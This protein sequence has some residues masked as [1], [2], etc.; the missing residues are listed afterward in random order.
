MKILSIVAL[1]FVAACAERDA[2]YQFVPNADGKGVWRFDT[3]TGAL[4]ACGWESSTP[5]CK[6]FPDPRKN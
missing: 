4:E 6:P 3:R 2:R 1:L 5:V